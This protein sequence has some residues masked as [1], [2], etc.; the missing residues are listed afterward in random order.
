V[1]TLSW[2]AFLALFGRRCRFGCAS[3]KL[4]AAPESP[5]FGAVLLAGIVLVTAAF[6]DD[7]SIAYI[8]HHSN[9]D[10]ARRL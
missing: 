5:A 8:F 2:R 9:R 1:R 3:A 6:N 7:F 4:P 10:L